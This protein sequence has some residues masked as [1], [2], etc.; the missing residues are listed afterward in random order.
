MKP[1][2]FF[3][4]LLAVV[5]SLQA[6]AG[7][8]ILSLSSDQLSKLE[9]DSIPPWPEG[10]VSSGIN[11][12]WQKI[13]HRGEYVVVV[14]EAMPAVIDVQ[15]PW[16]YD[17]FVQ[18]LRGE[19]ILTPKVG[20]KQTYGVGDSFLLPKGW[21]GTWDMPVKFREMIIVETEAWVAS[22]E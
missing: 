22:E 13:V 16:P 7:P 2:G 20:D 3:V 8:G 6:N 10:V 15:E 19:V 5:L 11:Q 14:Y 4:V 21:Q 9:L 12:H 18:V 17:E 1:L